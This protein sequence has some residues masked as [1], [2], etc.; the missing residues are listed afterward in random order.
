MALKLIIELDDSGNI[1]VS[2]EGEK[3]EP[4]V[5]L[6]VLRSVEHNLLMTI[7]IMRAEE[8]LKSMGGEEK[9]DE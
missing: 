1:D 2:H 5:L 4:I 8:T 3:V 7:D 9:K 6:G